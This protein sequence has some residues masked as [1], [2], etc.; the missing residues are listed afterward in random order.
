MML[1]CLKTSNNYLK[2]NVNYTQ[3][4]KKKVG[5]RSSA[6]RSEKAQA[7]FD[8]F[9]KPQKL[10]KRCWLC[11]PAEMYTETLSTKNKINENKL[12]LKTKLNNK[13]KLKQATQKKI[14]IRNCR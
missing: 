5:K 2:K 4:K 14:L 6:G 12:I 10:G 7:T 3:V 11:A 1:S 9:A 8:R 13:I